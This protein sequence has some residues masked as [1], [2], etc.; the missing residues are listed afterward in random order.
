MSTENKKSEGLFEKYVIYHGI[1]ELDVQ[2]YAEDNDNFF[3]MIRIKPSKQQEK[4]F[5]YMGT[6]PGGYYLRLAK[7]D[8]FKAGITGS[9]FESFFM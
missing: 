1:N 2:G 8:V 5:T 9:F 3:V 6:T 4:R 7:R